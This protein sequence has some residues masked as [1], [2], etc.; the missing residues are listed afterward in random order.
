MADPVGDKV[1]ANFCGYFEAGQ[2]AAGAT[3][4]AAAQRHAAD[5]LFD[6]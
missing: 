4:D 1:R 6:L 2:P 3:A 5:D